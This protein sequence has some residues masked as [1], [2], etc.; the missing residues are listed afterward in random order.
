M[1]ADFSLR[2]GDNRTTLPSLIDLPET[3]TPARN[4]IRMRS[5]VILLC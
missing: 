1:L 3:D 4:A 5:A 2:G